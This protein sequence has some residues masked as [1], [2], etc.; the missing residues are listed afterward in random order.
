MEAAPEKKLGRK[1]GIAEKRKKIRKKWYP[2]KGKFKKKKKDIR[3]HMKIERK[4]LKIKRKN[5]YDREKE[6]CGY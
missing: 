2:R 4:E 5:E 3:G 6:K 1:G